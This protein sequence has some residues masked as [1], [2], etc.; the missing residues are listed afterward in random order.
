MYEEKQE[1]SYTQALDSAV[2]QQLQAEIATSRFL[3]VAACNLPSCLLD[4]LELRRLSF[5]PG[6]PSEYQEIKSIVWY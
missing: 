6:K 1:Y 5:K 3:T 4:I 2:K